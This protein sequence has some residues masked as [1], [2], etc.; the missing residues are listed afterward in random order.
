MSEGVNGQMI[1]GVG[2]DLCSISRMSRFSR[3]D[4]FVS[5]VFSSE[6]IDYA[7]SKHCPARHLASSF[8]AREAFSK[9]SGLPLAKVAFKG[10]SVSRSESG[11]VLNLKA[12][13]EGLL[14]QISSSRFHLSLSHEGDYAVAFVVME[15]D[16]RHD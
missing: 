2:V 14:A 9:A 5:R 3:D 7:F 4:H 13:D 8:A 1:L 15:G 16:F 11:P 12:L 10:V 6:E